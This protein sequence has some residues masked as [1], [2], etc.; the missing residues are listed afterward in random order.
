MVDYR[1]ETA[2]NGT[3]PRR[4]TLPSITGRMPDGDQ[5]AGHVLDRRDDAADALRAP[6]ASGVP[7]QGVG[8]P[9]RDAASLRQIRDG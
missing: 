3:R 8:V 2:L 4:S 7:A 1:R 9:S 5:I 6:R